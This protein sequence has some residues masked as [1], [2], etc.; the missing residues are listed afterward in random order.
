MK[1]IK[2]DMILTEAPSIKDI[3]KKVGGAIKT[4]AVKAKDYIKNYP[5][6]V[7]EKNIA[8]RGYKQSELDSLSTDEILNKI[9]PKEGYT[10]NNAILIDEYIS[11]LEEETGDTAGISEEAKSVIGESIAALGIN[12]NPMLKFIKNYMKSGAPQLDGDIASMVYSLWANDKI[13]D[14]VI[15]NQN[16]YLYNK[17]VYGKYQDNIIYKNPTY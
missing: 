5:G 2:E 6:K 15:E 9:Q 3:A 1:L 11:R 13:S 12:D 17:K 16:S 14:N 10:G 7:K 4:G 8:E